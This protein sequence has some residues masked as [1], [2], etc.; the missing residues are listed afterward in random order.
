MLGGDKYH[1]HAFARWIVDYEGRSLNNDLKL[2]YTFPNR[3]VILGKH[4]KMTCGDVEV[5]LCESVEYYLTS[6]T[7]REDIIKIEF[8]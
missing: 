1:T 7:D 2:A 5:Y 6:E 4:H 3:Q 8:M